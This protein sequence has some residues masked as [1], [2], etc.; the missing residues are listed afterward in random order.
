MS[1]KCIMQT[2]ASVTADLDKSAAAADSNTGRYSS[3]WLYFRVVRV[4]GGDVVA[5]V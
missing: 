5:A 4:V 1:G 2:I 3:W